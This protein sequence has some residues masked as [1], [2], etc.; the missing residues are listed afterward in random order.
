MMPGS[1]LLL[2][3]SLL[4]AAAQAQTQTQT[5]GPPPTTVD[6]VADDFYVVRGEG[7]NTSVYIS[8]DGI[9]LVD[10]KF[11]RNHADLIARVGALSNRPIRYVF[12]THAHGD[13]TGG[14]VRLAPAV[15]VGH[16]SQREIMLTRKL[17]GPPQLTYS[18]EL[19]LNLGGKDTVARYLG[20]CHTSGDSFILFPAR[21]VV[22]TG[23]CITTGTPAAANPPT[24]TRLFVDYEN[25]G[26][27]SQAIRTVEEVLKLD[28][29]TVVPGHGPLVTKAD[30]ARWHERLQRLQTRVSGLLRE[31]KGQDAVL[32][33]LLKEFEWDPRSA[34]ERA[35]GLINELKP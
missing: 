3:A 17:P 31:G 13:H 34:A 12:N 18:A 30:I 21:R 10:P 9:V 19:R 14:N 32:E 29:D 23:D 27:F 8:D 24:S 1:A 4:T 26:S 2:L 28:F 11:E 25:G 5:Q 35:V 7:G 20:R 6:K 22:A 33:V 16:A 15:I